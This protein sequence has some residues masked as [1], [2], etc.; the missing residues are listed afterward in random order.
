MSA[1]GCSVDKCKDAERTEIR[2]TTQGGNHPH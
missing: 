2:G 1:P